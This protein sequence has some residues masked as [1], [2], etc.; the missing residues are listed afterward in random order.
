LKNK[1]SIQFENNEFKKN[2]KIKKI[3]EWIN[4][5][6]T[7]LNILNKYCSIFFCDFDTIK[8][9]NQKYRNKNYITDVL[10]FSQVG[11]DDDFITDFLGDVVICLPQAKNQAQ[12]QGHSYDSEV[13]FL[14]LHSI[15]HLIGYD[16]ESD[17]GEMVLLENQIFQ[18]LSGEKIE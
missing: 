15:L 4:N 6:F 12:S 9:L 8:E 10:S 7:E 1:T 2:I 18:K 11:G 13:N 5:V 16:H 14:I 3:R 17:D